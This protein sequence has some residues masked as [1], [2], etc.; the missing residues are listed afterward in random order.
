MDRNLTRGSLALTSLWPKSECPTYEDHL[1]EKEL[2]SD[3]E[4]ASERQAERR[5]LQEAAETDENWQQLLL[6]ERKVRNGD[7]AEPELIPCRSVLSQF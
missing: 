5:L 2:L 3:K 4:A 6:L 1:V 7:D